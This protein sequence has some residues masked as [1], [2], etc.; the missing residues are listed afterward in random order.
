[1]GRASFQTVAGL[2]Y[3]KVVAPLGMDGSTS[4]RIAEPLLA[5]TGA[6]N[7]ADNKPIQ[8]MVLIFMVRRF[9]HGNLVCKNSRICRIKLLTMIDRL[10]I[11]IT[12]AY[13]APNTGSIRIVKQCLVYKKKQVEVSKKPPLAKWL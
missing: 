4:T 1:M 9:V 8:M 7:M 13:R 11:W 6:I 2:G 12:M 5:D 3:H 10:L